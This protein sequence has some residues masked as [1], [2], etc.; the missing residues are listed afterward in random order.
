MTRFTEHRVAFPG[1]MERCCGFTIPEGGVFYAFYFDEDL[2]KFDM[3][4]R[5]ALKIDEDWEFDE[6]SSTISIGNAALPFLGLWG[7]SPLLIRNGLGT[8]N[9]ANSLVQLTTPTGETKSWQF[10]NFSGDW[11]QV[12][13]DRNANG[14][15]FGAPYD[16]DFRYVEL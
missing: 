4:N 11:E 2:T 8:L 9:I 14:F 6:Q 7:G 1:Y 12:T 13:F 5:Q 15:L 16:F 3:L 10:Q